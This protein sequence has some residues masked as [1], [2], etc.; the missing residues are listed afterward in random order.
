M[1]IK[2]EE[3]QGALPLPIVTVKVAVYSFGIVLIEIVIR[4]RNGD[5]SR[6][7]PYLPQTLQ[8]RAQECPPNRQPISDG[9]S[10]QS[11]KIST[12]KL[13]SLLP[14]HQV[15]NLFNHGVTLQN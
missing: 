15:I 12:L 11:M 3:L 9:K 8:K 13:L 2:C 5:R 6:S 4:G 7:S 1:G 14:K 10:F